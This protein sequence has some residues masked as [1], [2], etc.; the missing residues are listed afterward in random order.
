MK[1][2][3]VR[4]PMYFVGL[5]IM[6]IGIALSVKSNLGVSPVSSIP[7]TMTCVWGIEMGKATIIFHAALVVIQILI[8]RRNFKWINLLQVVVGIVF[9]YF[10]TFCNYLATFIPASD[11]IVL[12]LVLMLISTV[13][14]AAGI[15]FYLPADLIPLAGEGV[16]QAVSEVTH[17]EFSKVKIGFD[18]SMV[19]ISVVTCLI[20]IHSLGSVGIGTVIAAFLVGINLGAINRALGAKRDELLGKKTYTEEE[21]LRERM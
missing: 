14:I 5:F 9:G 8:L 13:F 1:N 19:L 4:I 17:I 6:T 21:V 15:F 10:T 7:Y 20:C 18:C 3:K 11:N 16:M 12:R 2:M